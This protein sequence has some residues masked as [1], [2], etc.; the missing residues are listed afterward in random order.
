[1]SEQFGIK[2][3]TPFKA[4]ILLK[5]SSGCC[6]ICGRMIDLSGQRHIDWNI[7]HFVP[8][9]VAKWSLGIDTY[10]LNYLRE[11]LSDDV[12]LLVTHPSCNESKGMSYDINDIDNLYISNESKADLRSFVKDVN[13]Y[14]D[15]YNRAVVQIK[16]RYKNRCVD[17]KK[18]ITSDF[19][20]RRIDTTIPRSVQNS[21]LLCPRCNDQYSGNSHYDKRTRRFR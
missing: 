11:L 5:K 9:A 17:C 4:A 1:M 12:N 10:D 7:D 16:T 19:V 18:E 8:K 13:T 2:S 6:A 21:V 15:E 14:L 3:V 20:L